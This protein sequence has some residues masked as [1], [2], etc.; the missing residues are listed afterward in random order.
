[1][2]LL[3]VDSL[4][5]RALVNRMRARA[6][7]RPLGSAQASALGANGGSASA[8]ERGEYTSDVLPPIVSQ[9][10]GMGYDEARVVQAY[11]VFGD[12][13]A[14]LLTYLMDAGE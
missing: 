13:H 5:T 7:A 4:L 12:D 3:H 14:S 6:R 11:T 9:L 8:F 2:T 10:V 1:M